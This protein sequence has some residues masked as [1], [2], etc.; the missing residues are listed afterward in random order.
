MRKDPPAS[1]LCG[2]RSLIQSCTRPQ[3]NEG[4]FITTLVILVDYDNVE[5]RHK[6]AGPLA[7]AR[8]LASTVPEDVAA[9]HNA[10]LVRLY[11]GWRARG[12]LT[13]LAQK[14]VPEI[15]RDSPCIIKISHTGS[16]YQ[17]KLTVELADG[18]IGTSISLQETLAR[19][20]GLRKFRSKIGAPSECASQST[21]GMS[22]YFGLSQATAC[23]VATCSRILGDV[24][25]RDEQKMVDTLIVA[26]IAANAIAS[27]ASDVVVVSS[28]IDMWPG[29]L[30]ALGSGCGVTHIHTKAGWRT[31]GH[32]IG[33]LGSHLGKKYRQLAV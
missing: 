21:C 10:F 6:A 7:L 12:S 22:Q 3:E 32:L 25:V 26:D 14:L 11:G 24:L 16:L 1:V 30:L 33:T 8:M 27:K 18:P 20:R 19:E 5:Q 2:T 4:R 15:R 28:D 23:S 31:Q 9:R 13:Q 29:V 17:Y